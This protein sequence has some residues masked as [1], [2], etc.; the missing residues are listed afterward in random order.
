MRY[1]A[2]FAAAALSLAA[3]A[4]NPALQQ[5]HTVYLLP[6]GSALDQF[7]ATRLTASGLFQVVTDPQKADAIFAERIGEGLEE[8]LNELYPPPDKPKP[9]DDDKD[10]DRDFSQKPAARVGSFGRARGT[11]FIVDRK[12]RNVLWSV[13]LP[14]KTSRA[15]EVN[16]RAQDIVKRLEKDLHPTK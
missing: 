5:V 10:K 4:P 8:K 15:A 11:V 3:D 2:L 7:L 9:K 14:T 6:M 13:Y 16:H 12:T 1:L